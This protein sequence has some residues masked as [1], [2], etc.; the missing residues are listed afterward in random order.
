MFY[1]NL[2]T[3]LAYHVS[4]ILKLS[5]SNVISELFIFLFCRTA[6]SYIAVDCINVLQAN[7]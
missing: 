6:R 5:S 3:K 7:K 4:Y 1:F 2:F